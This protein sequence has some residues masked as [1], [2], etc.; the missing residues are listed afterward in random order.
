MHLIIACPV[1]NWEP[2]GGTHWQCT[3]GFIWN[4]FDTGAKCLKC[5]KIWKETQCPIIPGGCGSWSKHIDWYQNFADEMQK[6]MDSI[7]QKSDI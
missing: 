2:D 4:T 1:C 6:E 7:Q 3:C 5:S